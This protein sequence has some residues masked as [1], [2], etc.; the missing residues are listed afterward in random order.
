MISNATDVKAVAEKNFRIR[1]P[2]MNHSKS[3]SIELDTM[4]CNLTMFNTKFEM[5][6]KQLFYLAEGDEP[7]SAFK[8][9][10]MDGGIFL[11][12]KVMDVWT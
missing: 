6:G 9:S 2:Y 4:M 12:R 11:T 5:K 7:N 1:Y 10:L 8:F 3:A